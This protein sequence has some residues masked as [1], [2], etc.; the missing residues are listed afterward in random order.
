[1]FRAS[2]A[3][4]GSVAICSSVVLLICL[5]KPHANTVTLSPLRSPPASMAV[6]IAV[7]PGAAST[8]C[9]P[10]ER[11]STTLV[12]LTRSSSAKICCASSKPSEIEVLPFADIEVLPSADIWSIPSSISV[13]FIDHGTR[14]VALSAKDTTEKRA[15]LSPMKKWFTS[16]L[17]K[18]FSPPGPS[19][20]SGGPFIEPLSSS[21]RMKSSAVA[22]GGMGEGGAGG[23]GSV[24]GAAGG[25]AGGGGDG[26]GDGIEKIALLEPSPLAVMPPLQ[27]GSLIS[28]APLFRSCAVWKTLPS[29]ESGA[30]VALVV[31]MPRQTVSR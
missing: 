31:I 17:A 23:G 1:M 29:P 10:S 24:G 16:S 28:K 7:L 11:S 19:M 15:I 30:C 2:R 5:P 3:L 18:A 21:T 4:D 22:Q 6:C 9:S 13:S 27:A 14:I 12:A 20:T 26:S 8:V 25:G